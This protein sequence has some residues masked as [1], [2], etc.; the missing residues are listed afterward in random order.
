VVTFRQNES[1]L[2]TNKWL[3][4]KVT[5]VRMHRTNIH[6]Y[7]HISALYYRDMKNII[8]TITVNI[9]ILYFALKYDIN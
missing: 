6:T 1:P 8:Y 5:T 3:G 7:I 9:Y 4:S 2:I